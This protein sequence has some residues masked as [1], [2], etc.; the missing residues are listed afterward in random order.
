MQAAF[1]QVLFASSERTEPELL[2]TLHSQ[3]SEAL[4]L[5]LHIPGLDSNTADFRQMLAIINSCDNQPTAL[6]DVYRNVYDLAFDRS[7][8]VHCDAVKN[9]I[10]KRKTR[11]GFE[12]ISDRPLL[13]PFDTKM[14]AA[15]QISDVDDWEKCLSS[16]EIK[17]VRETDRNSFQPKSPL[18]R[19]LVEDDAVMEQDDEVF[20]ARND[21]VTAKQQFV[22]A[23]KY[24]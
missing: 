16:L 3:K 4:D 20:K 6:C 13:E 14:I 17:V 11:K 23:W 15:N 18:K 10:S 22:C 19:K 21:F 8:S 7:I 2:K 24:V 1:E 12:Q 5:F 9:V